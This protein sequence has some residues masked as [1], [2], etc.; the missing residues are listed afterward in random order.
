[1]SD[2]GMQMAHDQHHQMMNHGGGGG[3]ENHPMHH[4]TATSMKTQMNQM[5]IVKDTEEMSTIISDKIHHHL[6]ESAGDSHTMMQMFFHGGCD[7]V[8]LFDWWRISTYGGL[9][10]SMF[11][12]VV[13]AILY[14][15]LKVYREHVIWKRNK[16]E[17]RQQRR[18]NQTSSSLATNSSSDGLSTPNHSNRAND[19][20]EGDAEIDMIGD[21]GSSS[22]RSNSEQVRTN[23]SIGILSWE[24][25]VSTI[26][27]LIQISLAYILML[28][29]MTFN[30]WLCLSVVIGSTL[31][32]F[33]IGW[34][35]PPGID[36]S[37]HCH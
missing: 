12:C 22:S 17:R 31:G 2:L 19:G 21:G 7:E 30:T 35:R 37:D 4:V 27:H 6:A 5:N 29:V 9:A 24:H 11:V 33:L 15:L 34:K 16:I 8:I 10:A 18:Y 26:L 14:E 36:V 25:L 32:Y 28:I 3:G 1:M 23:E 20:F 13:L